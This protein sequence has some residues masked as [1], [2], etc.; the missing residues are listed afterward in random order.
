MERVRAITDEIE[1][2]IEAAEQALAE[3]QPGRPTVD[4][5]LE[6]EPARFPIDG[7]W[8]AQARAYLVQAGELLLEQRLRKAWLAQHA[9]DVAEGGA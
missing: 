9:G 3:S 7:A 5:M 6:S 2:S 4:K 1:F 8:Q